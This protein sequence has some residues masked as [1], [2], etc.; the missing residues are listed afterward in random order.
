VNYQFS[1]FDNQ[2]TYEDQRNRFE[3]LRFNQKSEKGVYSNE[4]IQQSNVWY[5]FVAVY[6]MHV[7][8]FYVNGEVFD[9]QPYEVQID[10]MPGEIII[11][12]MK[13]KGRYVLPEGDFDGIIDELMI[14]NR[15]LTQNE[16]KFIY[17][18]GSP[19]L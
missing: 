6:D 3:F 13:S 9:S 12:S 17:E 8:T 10:T 1:I 4:F 2:Y 15:C 18:T 5:N 16:I 11:G 7:A 14:F 19:A